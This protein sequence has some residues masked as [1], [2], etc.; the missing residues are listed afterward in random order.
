MNKLSKLLMNTEAILLLSLHLWNT[1]LYIL[2]DDSPPPNLSAN[3]LRRA[4]LSS[5]LWR[6]RVSVGNKPDIFFCKQVN[7]LACCAYI[8]F[9][10][11]EGEYAE[12]V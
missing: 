7:H 11:T 12:A 5:C 1:H 3:S 9:V 6:R 10:W 8:D 4:A 2:A